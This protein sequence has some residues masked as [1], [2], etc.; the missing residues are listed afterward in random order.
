MPSLAQNVINGSVNLS[1]LSLD[2]ILP[3]LDLTKSFLTFGLVHNNSAGVHPQDARVT[4]RLYDDGGTK[5]IRFERIDV[6]NPVVGDVDIYYQVMEFSSDVAVQRGTVD[7]SVGFSDIGE[8]KRRLLGI[9]TVD[10]NKSFI[11]AHHTG[12][13]NNFAAED[14]LQIR[15]DSASQLYLAYDDDGSWTEGIL[16]YQ[17]VEFFDDTYVQTINTN[18]PDT[19]LSDDFTINTVDLSRTFLIL[20]HTASNA[21]AST[22]EPSHAVSAQLLNSDTLRVERN[23]V[24]G[25]IHYNVFV[26]QLNN[27]SLVESKRITVPSGSLS[28]NFSGNFD[29]DKTM[30][31]SSGYS[32]YGSEVSGTT[33]LD[34]AKYIGA[35]TNFTEPNSF[36]WTRG[37]TDG[38]STVEVQA[39]QFAVD[40]PDPPARLK[41]EVTRGTLSLSGTNVEVALPAT[42]DLTKS[43]LFFTVEYTGVTLIPHY[44]KI[45]GKLYDDGGTPKVRFER[46]G[47]S[48][49]LTCHYQVVE[50]NNS[51]NVQ[52]GTFSDSAFTDVGADEEVLVTLAQN[53]NVNK[54]FVMINHRGGSIGDDYDDGDIF[55]AQLTG[56]ITLR[57]SVDD[58]FA[59][60]GREISWQVIEFTDATTVQQINGTLSGSSNNHTISPVDL[61]R[62]ALFTSGLYRSVT[63][64]SEEIFIQSRLTSSTGLIVERYGSTVSTDY[65]VFVVQFDTEAVVETALITIPD[66]QTQ[67]TAQSFTGPLSLSRTA[68]TTSGRSGHFG[69]TDDSGT[70]KFG[71]VSGYISFTEPNSFDFT[72]SVAAEE[73]QFFLQGIQFSLAGGGGLRSPGGGVSYSSTPFY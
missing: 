54:A 9:T 17:V 35:V 55:R 2:V 45:L 49:T 46:E 57:V 61:S 6:T 37:N 4:G 69:I 29:S 36:T 3:A 50:F 11:I 13:G 1:G 60:Q 7:L 33:G 27:D 18:I 25:K 12:D 51:V 67:L 40:T 72:V 19:S 68:F 52:R 48:E 71:Q 15:F 53:V 43:V 63:E 28:S 30:F 34:S 8:V 73:K 23:D 66:T 16:D 32:G 64:E 41:E 65:T 56:P 5:K 47:I 58:G 21:G 38:T 39:V 31:L 22:N 10:L 62:T 70:A 42:L 20:S 44:G 26:V 24:V 14:F 59:P